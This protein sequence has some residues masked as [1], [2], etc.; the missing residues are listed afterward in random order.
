MRRALENKAA[1]TG[2]KPLVVFADD[3][4]INILGRLVL[5]RA[6]ARS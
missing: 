6:E 1:R 2:V 5:E 3:D 4:K